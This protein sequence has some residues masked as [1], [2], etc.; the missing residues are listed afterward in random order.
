MILGNSE[1]ALGVRSEGDL[2]ELLK[3]LVE[4]GGRIREESIMSPAC[5]Q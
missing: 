2:G 3:L 1:L 4:R 5:L